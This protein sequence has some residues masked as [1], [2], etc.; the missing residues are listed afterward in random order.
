MVRGLTT[1]FKGTESTGKYC[2]SWTPCRRARGTGP[3]S[4]GLEEDGFPGAVAVLFDAASANGLQDIPA[5]G[6]PNVV[7]DG[8]VLSASSS[9]LAVTT[10]W[11]RSCTAPPGA[12]R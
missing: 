5:G 12:V 4:G 10:R 6:T 2:P 8:A 11:C 7:E 3:R 9:V 1:M